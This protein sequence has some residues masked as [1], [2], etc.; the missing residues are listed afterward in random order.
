[1]SDSKFRDIGRGSCGS[2]FEVPEDARAVAIK[3]GAKTQSIWNDYNLTNIAYNSHLGWS[4]LLRQHFPDR[5][6]PRVPRARNYNGPESEFWAASLERFPPGDQTKGA[7]FH[8][9]RI[10][11][12]PDS[13]REDLVRQFFRN[14]AQE[15]ALSNP[16][17]GDCLIRVY[18]GQLNPQPP[19]DSS[20]SLRNFPLYL[21]QARA[22]A[23][24]INAYAEEMALGLA[25]LHWDAKID[26]ADTEFVIGCSN[27]SPFG[28]VHPDHESTQPPI[29]NMSDSTTY[30]ETQLWMFDYDKCNKIDLNATGAEASAV[31][32]ILVAVTGN[33]PYFPHPTL[34]RDL[35]QLFRAAYLKASALVIKTNRLGKQ[36]AQMPN[37]L[38]D[39]WEEWGEKDS[40]E[41]A[42]DP[43]ERDC[44]EKEDTNDLW[45]DDS[46]GDDSEEDSIDE[47]TDEDENSDE[48]A[49]AQ[50]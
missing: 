23:L 1:M 18:L 37:T 29:S 39:E 34:D 10:F 26:S 2:V 15:A 33:D 40:E 6:V 16:D 50:T 21:D 43:F 28:D 19:M 20:D 45:S 31:K 35:W 47:E 14:G 41:Q 4:A 48:D 22:L 13:A 38:M 8:L 44:E 32:K 24:D 11:P 5:R 42:F 25:I 9:D 46:E 49:A 12:V 30:E 17:S 36:V 27:N 3:K 7:A